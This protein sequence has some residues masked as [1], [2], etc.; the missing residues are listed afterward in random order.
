MPHTLSRPNPDL[1][2]DRS[3]CFMIH[4]RDE[5]YVYLHKRPGSLAP[6]YVGKGTGHRASMVTGRGAH[7]ASIVKK[8]GGFDVAV[9][10]FFDSEE[11]SFAHERFLIASFKAVGVV[12]ANKTEGGDGVSGH[13]HTEEARRKMSESRKGRKMS[14]EAIEKMSRSRR[15][16]KVPAIG[17]A[18]RGRKLSDSHKQKIRDSHL[19]W[20]EEKR[21]ASSAH[22]RACFSK[23]VLCVETGKVFPSLVDA[24]SWLRDNGHPKASKSALSSCCNS[25]KNYSHAYGYAWRYTSNNER[26]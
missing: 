23:Q 19:A 6:F 5:F 14:P 12:L 24:T 21:R 1:P 18:M 2:G 4:R 26:N 15:G 20:D 10:E 25:S 8:H 17:D 9:V 3:D 11:E 7:W 22:R 13:R 16:R